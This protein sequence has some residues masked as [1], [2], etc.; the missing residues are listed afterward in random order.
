MHH[1]GQVRYICK[2]LRTTAEINVVQ[3]ILYCFSAYLAYISV[4]EI[5]L[6]YKCNKAFVTL[7]FTIPRCP[8]A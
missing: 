6:R 2:N 3:L 7:P 5:F 4:I 8:K 1:A